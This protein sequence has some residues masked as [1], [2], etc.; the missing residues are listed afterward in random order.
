MTAQGVGLIKKWKYDP[1]AFFVEVLGFLPYDPDAVDV[2]EDG[3]AIIKKRITGQQHEALKWLAVLIKAK[4]KKELGLVLTDIERSVVDK[5]GIS[6]RSGKGTGK[7]AFLAGA[8]IWFLVCWN[9]SRIVA[10]AGKKDQIK[11]VLWNEIVKWIDRSEKVIPGMLRKFLTVHGEKVFVNTD[12]NPGKRW[13]AIA[14][15]ASK[16]ASAEEQATTLQGHHDQ[17]MMLIADEATAVPE[18]VFQALDQTMSD[19]VNFMIVTFNPNRNSGFAYD[20][21]N[22]DRKLWICLHWNAEE[23]EIVPKTTIQRLAKKYGTDSNAYR[24]S[25]LGEFPRGETDCVIPLEWV[26]NAVDREISISEDDMRFDALDP[27]GEG[28]DASCAMGRTGPV[29]T[30]DDIKVSH[31]KNTMEIAYW[32]AGIIMD[33]ASDDY[34]LDVGGLGVGIKDRMKE[35]PNVD[36]PRTINF[37]GSAKDKDKFHRWIDEAWFKVRE[38]FENGTVSIPDDDELIMELSSR[39]YTE[40]KGKKKVETKK[41]LRARGL[42]SPNKADAFIMLHVGFKDRFYERPEGK[43]DS[44]LDLWEEYHK[45]I[46]YMGV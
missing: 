12:E 15:T 25:V 22:K 39:K 42:G 5:F 24:I 41:D 45:T 19:I 3:I 31:E 38:K 28:R 26:L 17:H 32:F 44:L 16:S 33:N 13:Y 2:S 30:M 21:H 4:K 7:T 37:N 9:Q 8:T 46:G 29:T 36:R 14:R 23:C 27:A 35:L 34:G 11:D 18:P 6:I 43:D 10:T 1:E 40:P 20:S